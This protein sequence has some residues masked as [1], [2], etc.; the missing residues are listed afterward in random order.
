MAPRRAALAAAA[1]LA[2]AAAAAALE[3][4]VLDTASFEHQTQAATGMT[5]GH[6]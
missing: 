1:L 3:V 4:V 2:V 5:T 6:W